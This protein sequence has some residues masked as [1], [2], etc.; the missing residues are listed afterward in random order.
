MKYIDEVNLNK[1]RVLLRCDFNVPI[2]NGIIEDDTRI[3][4]ALDTISILLNEG[5][6]IILMSH[7]GRIKTK[8][9]KKV[10]SLKMVSE[11]LA[12]YLKKEIVFFDYP[13]SDEIT[14]KAQNLK[15][16]EIIFL[17]NTRFCDEGE[18]LE[19]NNDLDLASY[20]ASLGDVFVLDAF[21]SMHRI[22]AST[23][24]ISTF[25][26]TYYGLTVKE[27]LTDLEPLI[28]D[29]KRPFTVFMGASKIED[30]I[31]Y[32]KQLLQKCDYLLLGGGVANSFLYS[33]GEDIGNSIHTTSK[34]SLEELRKLFHEYREKIVLPTDFLREGNEIHDIGEKTIEN[35]REYY[36]Q[37]KTIFMNGTPGQF[38]N[39][40]YAKGTKQLMQSLK[41]I[42]AIK[43]AGGGATLNAITK[44]GFEEYYTYLSSGGGA[45]LEYISSNHLKAMDY[46]EQNSKRLIKK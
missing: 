6:S 22:H 10:N 27:E 7:M 29:I 15:S 5:C 18:K 44:F 20:W 24:G 41:E 33:L 31:I 32:I 34:T 39:P 28:H 35:F 16:G 40:A 3:R 19:S 26:P 4:R 14:K 23:A 12:E 9:D 13:V 38:E 37:S 1:K 8:E 2:E 21:A 30:K 43:I 25:L 36:K 42:D 45:S 46:I 17:E 11:R